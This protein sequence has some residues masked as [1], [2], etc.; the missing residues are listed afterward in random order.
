V[1]NGGYSSVRA[2][3]TKGSQGGRGYAG[4][5]ISPRRIPR[6]DEDGPGWVE[7]QSVGFEFHTKK[8]KSAHA[9]VDWDR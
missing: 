4:L 7:Y 2:K 8:G 1:P 3:I 5:P 9:A 6:L